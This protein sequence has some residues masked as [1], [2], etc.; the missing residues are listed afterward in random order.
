MQIELSEEQ[1]QALYQLVLRSQISGNDAEMIV[2][3]KQSLAKAI[4]P[5]EKKK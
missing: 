4:Q 2:G 1:L 5:V 3:L